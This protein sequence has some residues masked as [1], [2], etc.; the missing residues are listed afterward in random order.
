MGRRLV[1]LLLV[2]LDR[3]AVGSAVFAMR[4][5]LLGRAAVQS[6]SIS[7]LGGTGSRETR[8]WDRPAVQLSGIRS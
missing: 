6:G 1:I 8:A 3:P 7:A 5:A 2:A 4:T